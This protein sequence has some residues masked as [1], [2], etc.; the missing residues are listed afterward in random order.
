GDLT[1]AAVGSGAVTPGDVHVYV[2]TSSWIGA[3]VERRLVDV[4]HYIG[5]IPSAVSGRYLLVAEQEVAGAAIDLAAKL[6]RVGY[7]ELEELAAE[8]PP[9]ARGLIFAPWMYGE[10]SPVDDPYAR[11]ALVNLSLEHGRED[12]A[13]AV[14]EGVAL[15]IA[16]SM[17]HF[18]RLAEGG[19]A[20][21]GVGGAL[22]IG[23]LCRVLASAL[24]RRVD[25][26]GD[27]HAASIRGIAVLA[28]VALNV[29]GSVDEAASAI[30]PARSCEPQPE[31]AKVYSEAVGRLEKL[32]A[33][34]RS[35]FREWNRPA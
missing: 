13:R 8:S 18:E 9:G 30:K 22:R 14:I 5:S 33:R 25:V 27:P 34:L 28:A 24:G 7:R 21:R 19:G 2:G 12:V 35:L 6:L 1:A 32:Y 10:R 29:Y 20:V 26:T 31:A 23:L 4:R 3:H 16:W 11:G 15:N 17:K